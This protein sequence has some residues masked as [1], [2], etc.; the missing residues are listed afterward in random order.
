MSGVAPTPVLLDCDPGHDDAVA[1]LLALGS[2]SLRLLG[3][4]TCFGNCAVEDATR[5]AQRV[6]A[7]AGRED[8]P[9]AVGAAGPM[10]GEVALG[11]YVHG[12]SG[13]D[14]PAL[15]EPTVAPVHETATEL[16]AR[17]LI[18]SPEPVTV[19]VTGP[20]T[21]LGV[22][23]SE[24]PG[25]TEHIREVIFMGGSTE[26]GNHTPTAEFNTF[27]D[28]EALDVVLSTG[29]PVRMVGLNLTHQALATPAVVERMSAMPHLVGRTCAEWMGFFGDSYERI[30]EFE[31]PPVHDPC[32]IAPLLDPDVI[33]WRDCFVAVELDGTWTRGTTVVD[34]FGRLPDRTPNAAVAMELDAERY[35]DLILTALDRLGSP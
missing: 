7:L 16:L 15:P 24:E 4:T 8:V 25:L 21:N 34:L 20:M 14:G 17:C 30:W 5:N 23:L 10:R 27:A 26:R 19:V 9:V 33:R 31:A 28:P 32:T 1:I 6:L 11:N 3:I 35:W 18:D 12:V 13:L 29:V 2:P 22:L